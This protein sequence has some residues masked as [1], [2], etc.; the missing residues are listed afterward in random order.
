MKP[1]SQFEKMRNN[2]RKLA[3]AKVYAELLNARPG[4]IVRIPNSKY[5]T[6]P[7]GGV[8]YGEGAP[9]ANMR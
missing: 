1:P 7:F 3:N 8:V 6:Q 4:Q 9:I 5:G 2:Q